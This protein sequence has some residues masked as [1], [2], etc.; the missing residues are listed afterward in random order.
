MEHSSFVIE[1]EKMHRRDILMIGH[2]DFYG[3]SSHS[4]GLLCY[5]YSQYPFVTV[6]SGE[7]IQTKI[8]FV[9]I[10]N[11]R[12]LLSTMRVMYYH[13]TY[14]KKCFVKT[15]SVLFFCSLFLV[16]D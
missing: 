7:L 13:H 1:G 9:A 2:L 8:V 12:I 15:T 5:F 14:V 4:F 16:A 11:A 3:K 10:I 6:C